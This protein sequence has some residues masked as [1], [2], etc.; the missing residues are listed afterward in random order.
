MPL[1]RIPSL[2]AAL[3][4]TLLVALSA[5][6]GPALAQTQGQVPGNTSG[7]SSDTEMWREIR[8]GQ[9][10]Q[11]TIPDPSAAVMIQSQGEDWRK[12]RTGL[13]PLYG[14][15]ALFGVVILLALFFA[16]RGRITIE[17]GWSGVL[18]ERFKAV[19]R[20]AHWLMA[21]SFIVLGV[22]GLNILYGKSVLKPLIGADAFAAITLAGKLAH[23]YIAFAFMAGLALSFVLWVAHNFPRT[24]DLIW[25]LKGGGMLFKSHPPAH[26]FNAG[27]KILFWLVM[28]GGLSISMSGIALMFPFETAMFAKTFALIN[29]LGFDLPT[30]LTAIQEMQ[31]SQLWHSIVAIFLIV[32]ILGHIYIG[33]LGMEGAFDAMGTGMVDRNWA[34]EHHALWVEAEDAKAADSAARHGRA[35]PAE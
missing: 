24:A 4:M 6:G 9:P 31:L 27:Q 11:V 10:G 8:R 26:K 7:G 30:N 33:T 21:G 34:Q 32:V 1:R 28:L 12:L 15:W 17:H 2:L 29:L 18:I 23:N 13:L 22:T 19:E 35:E 5:D 25:L 20:F 3:A 16:L 14:S